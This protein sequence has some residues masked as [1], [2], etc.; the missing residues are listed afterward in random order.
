MS[1]R[2]PLIAGV[3][4][5]ALPRLVAPF[6]VI[7]GFGMLLNLCHPACPSDPL[8]GHMICVQ[9]SDPEGYQRA[10]EASAGVTQTPAQWEADAAGQREL[11][12]EQAALDAQ[13]LA[14]DNAASSRAVDTEYRQRCRRGERE[15]CPA[16]GKGR[17]RHHRTPTPAESEGEKNE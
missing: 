5:L 2:N 8:T 13:H 6:L 10:L 16:H 3:M 9:Q 12:K 17:R 1:L 15:Y 11:A 7:A 14:D 4:L